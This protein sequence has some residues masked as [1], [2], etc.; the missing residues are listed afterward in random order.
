MLRTKK[1]ASKDAKVITSVINEI[2]KD[3][4][5]YINT[6]KA[7]NR[8]EFAGHQQGAKALNNDCFFAHPYLS[9]KRCSN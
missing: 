5:D 3:W 8:K 6:I 1:I 4:T 7:N 2:L 9:W